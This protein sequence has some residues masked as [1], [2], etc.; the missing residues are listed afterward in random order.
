MVEIVRFLEE[1]LGLSAF[2]TVLF[3]SI[4]SGAIISLGLFIIKKIRE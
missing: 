4:G 2:A 3:I 1:T